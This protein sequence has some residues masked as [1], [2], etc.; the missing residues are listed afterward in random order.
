M[1]AMAR[2][3]LEAT[4]NTT[5]VRNPENLGFVETC[6]RAVFEYDL[7]DNDVL[8]LNSDAELTLGAV[9]EMVGVLNADEKHGVVHPRSNEAT[10][11]SVPVLPLSGRKYSIEESREIYNQLRETVPRWTITPVA[12]GFCF[13]FRRALAKNYG[14]FDG[15]YSPGY[16]EENDF[17][18]RVNRLGYSA[19]LANHAF[20]SHLGS[21]SFEGPAKA[22]LVARND[23]TL[24][25]RYPHH[26]S[27]VPHYLQFVIEPN[28]WFADRLF[29]VGRKRVLIDLFHMSL[30][31][32]GSTR[33]AISF[34][35][36]LSKRLDDLDHIDFTIVSSAEAIEFFSL[37]QYG[38]PVKA[39]GTLDETFDLGFALSPVSDQR[40]INTLNRHCVRWV[41]CHF[42]IIALRVKTL[43]EF[44][45]TRRQVVLD[46]LLWADRVV[47]IS[48]SSVN[49]FEA[50][51]GPVVHGVRDRT[52]VLLEGVVQEAFP[53]TVQNTGFGAAA[54]EAIQKDNFVLVI[55]NQFPHKH[56]PEALRALMESSPRYDIVAFGKQNENDL[57]PGVIAVEA[58]HLSDEQVVF[59]YG[60]AKCVVFPSTYEGF[61]LPTVEVASLGNRIVLF[62]SEVSHE[63]AEGLGIEA[64]VRYFSMLDQLPAVVDEAVSNPGLRPIEMR[65]LDSYNHDLLDIVLNELTKP[66]DLQHLSARVW[67]FRRAETYADSIEERLRQLLHEHHA[68]LS[69]P[70]FRGAKQVA[71]IL[72]PL[73]PVV[74]QLVRF[75]RIV[76]SE[77]RK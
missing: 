39:N 10:I 42:D 64:N 19:V 9:P 28:D 24:V 15:V 4:P 60:K 23:R 14:L 63:V 45:F 62:D 73:K 1:E 41:V 2:E 54:D 27:A 3:L 55:G 74:R 11:A 51:F 6:N 37:K 44:N 36:V 69:S 76:R 40:Q 22:E 49:D 59:L 72:R 16:S 46:S 47:S 32:N 71:R 33:N 61:G 66:V 26:Q 68:L 56:F 13:L 8:L 34:L 12:V 43:L 65:T 5:Y 48:E 18:W 21:R 25:A 57:V 29:G 38:I 20:V 67:G 58:G 17:C 53:E 30:V 75:A 31:Y 70:S 7:S 35:E 77:L 50:Y 52:T